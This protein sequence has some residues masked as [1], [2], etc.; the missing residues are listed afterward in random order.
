LV[1][2]RGNGR[3]VSN[4]TYASKEALI[5][6]RQRAARL[7]EES[8]ERLGAEVTNVMELEVAIVGIRPPID[9]PAQGRP[10]QFP[11][12]TTA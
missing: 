4:V 9:L 12:D 3:A 7:R 11:S 2:N 1:V 6:S 10:V 5:A 8:V